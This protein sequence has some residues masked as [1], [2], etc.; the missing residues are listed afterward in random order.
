M[1]SSQPVLQTNGNLNFFSNYWPKTE[2]YSNR[3]NIHRSAMY[4][5]SMDLTQRA[6]QANGK[7]F[8]N[9]GIIFQISY[10]CL[11]YY[12]C[13]VYASD[14]GEAFVLNSTHSSLICPFKTLLQK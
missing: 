5:I 14:V 2:K 8:S 10:N 11:K 12:W 1:D 7:L 6:L 9:F 13:C 4:C 3:V